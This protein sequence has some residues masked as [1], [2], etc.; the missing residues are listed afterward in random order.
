M[1]SLKQFAAID[2]LAEGILAGCRL[3]LSRGI[4]LAESSR[5]DHQLQAAKLLRELQ[6]RVAERRAAS[7]AAAA[8]AAQ[9]PGP[10]PFR[11]GVSGPPGAGKSSL[12][13]TLGCAMLEAGDRVAVLAIDPSSQASGGAILGDKT[14]MQRLSSSPDAYVRPSPARGTLGGV[15]RATFDAIIIC[16]AAGYSKVLVETVGVGQSET[17]VQDLVDVFVLVLPPVGGDELQVIKRGVTEM[18]D[19]VV[20]NKADGATRAAASRAATAFK[21]TVHFH[22]QRRQSWQPAVLTASAH[23]GLG[24]DKLQHQ[25]AEYQAV[26]LHSGELAQLRREQRR[27]VA[28]TAAE[29]AVL[30]SF[31]QDPAVRYLLD[32]LMPDIVSGELAPRAAAELLTAWHNEYL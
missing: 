28:W 18:A 25:L 8:A 26:M 31:R 7:V 32:R 27:R 3:S 10:E 14:R 16:E 30:D 23:S 24:I 9:L 20:I 11:V 21:S 12:I 15:A 6:R 5:L 2:E 19:I 17:A 1:P 29:E 4:T 22:R 13:E